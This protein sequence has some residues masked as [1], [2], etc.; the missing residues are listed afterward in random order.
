MDIDIEYENL[1]NK[2]MEIVPFK[3]FPTRELVQELRSDDLK[4]TLKTELTIIDVKNSGDISGIVCMSEPV[5]GHILGCGLTHL[6]VTPKNPLYP[7]IIAYQK[8]R[9][10]RIRKQNL[11]DF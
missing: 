6:I 10:K 11:L 3:A 5:D 4:I 8:K 1:I 9:I 7:E 2:L